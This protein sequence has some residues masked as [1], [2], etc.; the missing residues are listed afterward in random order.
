LGRKE[1]EEREELIEQ[2][3]ESRERGKEVRRKE[4]VLYA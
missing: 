3:V 1:R 2:R 4:L